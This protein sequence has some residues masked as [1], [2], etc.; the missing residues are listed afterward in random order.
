V[1][2]G[3]WLSASLHRQESLFF[4]GEAFSLDLRGWKAAPTKS[5]FFPSAPPFEK[6]G[7]GD[8]KIDFLGKH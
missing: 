2:S 4:A 1:S 3:G 5:G 6:G 7:W 8:F